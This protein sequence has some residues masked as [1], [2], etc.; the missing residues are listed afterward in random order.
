MDGFSFLVHLRRLRANNNHISNVDGVLDLDGL[1][2]LELS[3]NKITSVD[4]EGSELS[5][6]QRLDLSSNQVEDIKHLD[7]LPALE[8]L[9]VSRNVLVSFG[10]SSTGQGIPLQKLHMS[11]NDI[12]VIGLKY[13]PAL[14]HLD[15]DGNKIREIQGLS[16]AYHLDFLSLR[17]QRAKSDIVEMVLTTANECR[18]IRLSSNSVVEGTFRLPV[19]PQN[20]LRELEIAA[21][22]ILTL[23]ERSACTFPTV[24][25]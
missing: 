21:C 14:R 9:D 24:G 20:S 16:S 5:R 6:L 17:A 15:I 13:L 8:E 19:Q 2:E 23:P 1:L 25:T 10:P 12:E 7:C 18:H 11:H 22:G 3:G 4:F